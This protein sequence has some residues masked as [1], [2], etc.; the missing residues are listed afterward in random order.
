MTDEVLGQTH[1][2]TVYPEGDIPSL[3]QDQAPSDP[4]EPPVLRQ[5]V[6]ELP[7]TPLCRKYEQFH[8]GSE[9]SSKFKVNLMPPTCWNA[10]GFGSKVSI[11]STDATIWCLGR[12]VP[13]FLIVVYTLSGTETTVDALGHVLISF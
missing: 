1:N 11:E 9:Q 7:D 10:S 6:L 2:F 12:P 5:L 4:M 8:N 3:R 13:T